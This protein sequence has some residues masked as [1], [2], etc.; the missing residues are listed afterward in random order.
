MISQYQSSLSWFPDDDLEADLENIPLHVLVAEDDLSTRELLKTVLVNYG[1]RVSTAED[2]DKAWE[3]LQKED[4]LP[5]LAILDW[6]MPGATGPELCVRLKARKYPFVY[7]VL[8]TAR[9]QESDIIEG[10][11]SGAHEF[12]TKP[13]NFHILAARVAAGA[14]IVRLEKKLSIKSEILKEY[15]EKLERAGHAISTFPKL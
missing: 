12:L 5:E 3:L 6:M 4:D 8:L 14:R 10:L 15:A 2:G 7:T 1:Y 11:E 9:T 13:F